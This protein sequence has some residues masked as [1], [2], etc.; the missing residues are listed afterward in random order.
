[1]SYKTLLI[2]LVVLFLTT[3]CGLKEGV[4][5]KDQRSYL[6]FTGNTENAT[7]YIDDLA[8]IS[9]NVR[10]AERGTDENEKSVPSQIN[11]ALSPG[12]HV[13]VVKKDE[14]EVVNRK[15]LLGNGMTKEIQIP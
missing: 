5:Q 2:S 13:I 9:L 12:K 3:S 15:V 10:V 8:P 14:I 1:M 6:W 7:V 11:Y 4:V